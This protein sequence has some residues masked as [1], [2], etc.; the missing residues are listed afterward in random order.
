MR[1]SSVAIRVG[2]FGVAAGVAVLAGK[3]AVKTLEYK[4]QMAVQEALIDA[5]MSWSRVIA[6]GLQIVLEG[7]APNE[8]VRLRAVTVAGQAVDPSRVINNISVIDQVGIDAPDFALE[9]LRNDS[10]VFLIGLIPATTDRDNL[11]KRMTDMA[12]GLPV[13]DLMESADYPVP[14]DWRPA[15]NF[16]LRALEMLPR[17]KISV[18]AGEV[19]VIA[20][21][22]SADEKR[23]VEQRLTSIAPDD[24]IIT[25]EIAAPRPVVSPYIT[26][27]TIDEN[28]PAFE[29]C[30]ADTE[31]AREKIIAAAKS[32][33]VTE[34]VTC[35]LALGVPSRT[36]GDAVAL[37]IDA[38]AQLGG[39]T[40]TIS[41]A[42]ISLVG[43]LGTTQARFDQVVGELDNAL[44]ELFALDATLP[45]APTDT[46]EGPPQFSAT[47]SPE[48][49]VQ[50]RGRIPNDLT[51]TVV[52]NYASARFPGTEIAMGT[53]VGDGLPSDWQVR[54]LA[55]VEALSRLSNGSVIVEPNNLIITGVTNDE[56]AQAEISSLLVE[57]LG[58]DAEFSVDVEFIA[59]PD[60]IS[61]QPTPQECLDQ[62]A[63]VTGD[64]KITFDPGKSTL[65]SESIPII[66]DIADI[67][68]QC[69]DIEL[70][71]AGYTDSQG[72]E[73]MNQNLS[74]QR[75][76]AVLSA[77]RNRRIPTSS[78]VAVG[79]GEEN[80][81]A[82]N[83]T[84]AGRE[85]NR[86]IEF[87]LV[88]A[89][90]PDTT[91]TTEEANAEADDAA[92]AE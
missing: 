32:A 39:G 48:G 24:I 10:G 84:E 59:L 51:N 47:L 67:M 76:E 1:L 22:D 8:V 78:F 69:V 63:L 38:I 7:D 4:S 55:A 44:P 49:L 81:I 54:A 64:R 74:Q 56:E 80:P 58:A 17:S 88:A 53:R 42:D 35:A 50:L 87:H 45:D 13:S 36:W 34:D 23:R 3:A 86:R 30:T 2:A 90:A 26:R 6:D 70:E 91:E 52:E 66:D 79:Y 73:E 89:D 31:E 72:S 33:G 41:D 83:E 5:D 92:P 12:N 37:S 15:I 9:I 16:G 85:A 71:I 40:V 11:T 60:P 61:D 29:A 18:A 57:K 77:L 14:E 21:T 28:G 75:A 62:I 25:L 65:S 46:E 82:D 20:S 27:F 68:R 43:R 19:S